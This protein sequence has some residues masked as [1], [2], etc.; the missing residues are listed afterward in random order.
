M[1]FLKFKCVLPFFVSLDYTH[2]RPIDL[3]LRTRL[4]VAIGFWLQS[5]AVMHV[6]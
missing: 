5:C 6:K 4:V 1:V 2:N 3:G